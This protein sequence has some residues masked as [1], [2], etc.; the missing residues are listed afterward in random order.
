MS[1]RSDETPHAWVWSQYRGELAGSAPVGA[2][3]ALSAANTVTSEGSKP[4]AGGAGAAPGIVTGAG[5]HESRGSTGPI[6]AALILTILGLL[7]LASAD[8]NH[9]ANDGKGATP[10][11][12]TSTEPSPAP[13]SPPVS[14][15]ATAVQPPPEPAPTASPAAP[16]PASEHHGA[17]RRQRRHR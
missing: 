13:A 4:S 3:Q 14:S 5:A 12:T 15:G 2:E 16:G 9:E 8:K 17:Q 10:S 11:V 7:W 6:L 1:N